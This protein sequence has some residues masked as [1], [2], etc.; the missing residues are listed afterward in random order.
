LL[1]KPDESGITLNTLL[2]SN[3]KNCM[4]IIS[5]IFKKIYKGILFESSA[6]TDYTLFNHYII[7]II[8]EMKNFFRNIMDVT[9]PKQ[10]EELLVNY[11]SRTE[12]SEE[13]EIIEQHQPK[14]NYDYFEE[15]P[16]EL[17]N[18]QCL[19]L[20]IQDILTMWS[21]FKNE[22]KN[23]KHDNSFFRSLEKL[24]NQEDYLNH[25]LKQSDSTIYFLIFDTQTNPEKKKYLSN[26][27]KSFTFTDDITNNEFIL[28]RVKYSIKLVLRG[29]NLINKKVYSL[30]VDADT[31]ER[32][33]EII[34]K[35]I[36]VEEDMCENYL[37]NKIPLTWYSLYMKNNIRN[38]PYEYQENNFKKLYDE[39]LFES[40]EQ[41]G[42]LNEKS[43]IVIKQF[44]LNMRCAEMLIEKSQRDLII[45]KRIEKFLRIDHFIR[46]TNIEACVKYHKKEHSKTGL[47]CYFRGSSD[48]KSINEEY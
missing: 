29:L 32:F 8:P 4:K 35:I 45:I 39:I 10:I 31:N 15:N 26:D 1:T 24:F 5:N 9:L 23:F 17:I 34:N 37:S 42:F 43:N 46:N 22:I 20:N 33:L 44:G 6:E 18:I 16:E 12:D 2:S 41:T 14:I 47:L 48:K 3:T 7:E 13:F 25:I 28:Q 11:F 27:K 19:C 30:L 38:I 21:L 36:E 40:L